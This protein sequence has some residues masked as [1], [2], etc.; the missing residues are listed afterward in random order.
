[1]TIAVSNWVYVGAAWLLAAGGLGGYA[2]LVLARGRRLSRQVSPDRR[3][4][5]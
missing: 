4:F 5:L 2:G 3:R 1:M